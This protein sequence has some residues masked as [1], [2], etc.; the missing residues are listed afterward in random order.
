[1]LSALVWLTLVF[2]RNKMS[3]LYKRDNSV[4]S[5]VKPSRP[6]P[7]TFQLRIIILKYDRIKFQL[8]T[9]NIRREINIFREVYKQ[10]E[11]TLEYLG[12]N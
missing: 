1:M 4:I 6:T 8:M 9:L 11:G 10:V 2:M 5:C 12:L 7:L 3:E